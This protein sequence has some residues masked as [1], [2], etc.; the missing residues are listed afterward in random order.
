MIDRQ[1]IT[2]VYDT[3][4]IVDI[5]SDY[6][7]L[8][9]R[10]VNYIGLCPF[11]TE[12]TG[13]FTVSPGK[14]IFKCFGCGEAGNAV[15]FIQK[16]ER[17][18]FPE[19]I[20]MLARKYNIEV[21][22]TEL[23]EEEK[24]KEQEREEMFLANEFALKWFEDQLWNTD[25]GLSVGLGYLHQRGLQDDIIR[26]FRIGYA[27]NKNLLY[28]DAESSGMSVDTLVEANL[29][30]KSERDTG[31]KY[32]D[33]F[34]DR[35]I[36]PWFTLSNKVVAFNGRIL[37]AR[38]NTGKYYNSPE[39]TGFFEKR[40]EL[41]GLNF[42]RKAIQDEKFCYLMEGQMDVISMVQAGIQNAVASSGTALTQQHV[43]ILK[44]FTSAATLIYDS[45]QAGINAASKATKLLFEADFNVKLI[46]LPEGEDPDSLSHKMNAAD[47]IELLQREQV[48]FIEYKIK[49]NKQ[50]LEEDPLA[51]TS[52]LED[53]C[54]TISAI[55]DPIKREVYIKRA[56]QLLNIDYNAIKTKVGLLIRDK[57]IQKEKDEL[58]QQTRELRDKEQVA[59]SSSEETGKT[60]TTQVSNKVPDVP[61]TR[62]QS[63][64]RDILISLI[65]DG[66]KPIMTYDDGSSLTMASF[67]FDEL[68]KD[69]LTFSLPV[70]QRF[71]KEYETKMNEEDFNAE[72]Y[73]STHIDPE[74]AAL[75]S[76]LLIE[77][78]QVSKIFDSTITS[79]KEEKISEEKLKRLREQ[80]TENLYRHIVKLIIQLKIA[81]AE[82]LFEQ[83]NEKI[84]E[85]KASNSLDLQKNLEIH[86]VKLLKYK[87]DL[88]KALR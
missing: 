4:N 74:L 48:D 39:K 57:I 2:R 62:R 68:R 8:R 15:S 69:G 50:Q 24:K 33:I 60:S 64:E 55:L 7:S 37:H 31:D 41:F 43:S 63:L 75:A 88:Q 5:I 3:A 80:E 1:T 34:R 47:F 70:H 42:A 49:V 52:L 27:P 77:K 17:C 13:S 12:K 81:A 36:F 66:R 59:D 32:Y 14:G 22:E 83:L 85:A 46:L 82:E 20:K 51:L 11:H 9:K 67:V 18:S 19:A 28:K 10:G 86:Q 16:I 65:K 79:E 54:E 25:E 78:Y 53:I 45:D 29:C 73:F 30:G 56:S 76:D 35:V 38:E 84:K 58:R 6:V 40:R 61:L 26:K 23:T 87:Q 44:R 72:H 21:V 71:T